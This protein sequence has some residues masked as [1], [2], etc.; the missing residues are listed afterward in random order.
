[1]IKLMHGDSFKM[2]KE[3]KD[4]S[5]KLVQTDVPYPDMEI[6]DEKGHVVYAD[7]WIK[8]FA[9]MA[10]DI[11][12][13]LE[14]GGSFVTTINC[15][16]DFSFFYKW[17]NWMCELGFTYVYDW[18]WI[19][20]NII[21][22][23]MKRPRD[24]KDYIAH[25]Y[26]GSIDESKDVYNMSAIE[27]WRKYNPNTSIPTNLIYASNL[28]DK[29]YYKISKKL[30]I[31]HPGKYPS[32]I[33]ELFIKLLTDEGD[34]V[35]ELFNGSGTTSIEASILGR[36]CIAFEYNDDFIKLAEEQYKDLNLKYKI[37]KHESR[38]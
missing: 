4:E 38:R 27:D 14:D 26:K 3:I 22:G 17:V 7:S 36:K 30:G 10:K 37:I 21:P 32:L 12:R 13:V 18:Y 5:I 2:I 19:K 33:P 15:K 25:F 1:M 34:V 23:K 28:N 29:D 24:S 16:Y 9:P 11:Y 6:H 31:K 8:W 35:L 20:Q